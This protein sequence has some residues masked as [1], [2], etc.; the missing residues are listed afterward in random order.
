MMVIALRG[1]HSVRWQ[2]L[3]I[4]LDLHSDCSFSVRCLFYAIVSLRDIY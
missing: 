1:V 2:V 4:F 3:M